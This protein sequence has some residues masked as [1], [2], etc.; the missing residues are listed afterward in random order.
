[1]KAVKKVLTL[2]LILTIISQIFIPSNVKA[3]NTIRTYDSNS[4]YDEVAKNAVLDNKRSE[5]VD[6]DTGID[7]TKGASNTNGQ[8]VYTI[9]STKDDLYPIHYYRGNIDNNNVLFGGFCWQIVRTTETGG[10]K[11]IYNGLPDE[12]GKCENAEKKLNLQTESYGNIAYINS[13]GEEKLFD[14]FSS[15]PIEAWYETANRLYD[16]TFRCCTGRLSTG[17]YYSQ[18]VEYSKET[19]TY[20]LKNAQQYK[21]T[22]NIIGQTP[23][24]T[25]SNSGATENC[26]SSVKLILWEVYDSGEYLELSNGMTFE[27]IKKKNIIFGNDVDYKNEKYELKNIINVPL[28]ELNSKENIKKILDGHHYFCDDFS[29][30]CGKVNYIVSFE[31]NYYYQRNEFGSLWF[32]DGNNVNKIYNYLMNPSVEN[33]SSMKKVIDN[34]YINYLMYYTKYLEDTIWYS[35]GVTN[36]ENIFNKNSIITRN[37]ELPLNLK[38]VNKKNMFTTSDEYGNGKLKYPSGTITAQE[39]IYAGSPILSDKESVM[40]RI[41]AIKPSSYLSYNYEFITMSLAGLYNLDYPKMYIVSSNGNLD[42]SSPRCVVTSLSSGVAPISSGC[43][44]SYAVRPM[45]SLKHSMVVSSGDGRPTNP[46]EVVEGNTVEYVID[47]DMPNG[48]IPPEVG[49]YLK[50]SKVKMNGL[51]AGDIIN[52]YRFLGWHT[53][54]VEVEGDTFDMPENKVVFVGKFEK[55][56]DSPLTYDSIS[57]YLTT[58][59]I[60]VVGLFGLVLLKKKI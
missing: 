30:S 18:E 11:L 51:K 6:S 54:D 14:G 46:Y 15:L 23:V 26:G 25:C 37:Y 50:G 31:Y 38:F 36:Y 29:D 10:V 2:L 39:V 21:S 22:D 41:G 27:D 33:D 28:V 7:F 58:G 1:M 44:G 34:F 4:L 3:Q 59:I 16:V 13:S 35:N 43:G 49:S 56:E 42:V 19:N 24:Y 48:F 52:G 40:S 9:A 55:I 53:E 60:G 57:K 8:G 47:G 17:D 32:S 20:T 45:V 12:N 5:Y